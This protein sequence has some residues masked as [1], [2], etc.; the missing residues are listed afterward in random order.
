M[1]LEELKSRRHVLTVPAEK[2]GTLTA[3][4]QR[5]I[6]SL[7]ER[8]KA[9]DARQLASLTRARPF[10]W[11]AAAVWTAGVVVMLVA[12]VESS[13]RNSPTLLLQGMLALVFSGL[14]VALYVQLKRISAID[15]TEAATLFLRKAARRYRFMTP[16]SFVLSLL[17]SGVM[18]LA[19]STYIVDV[20][21]RYLGVEN[22]F[23]GIVSTFVFVGLVYLFGYSVTKKAWKETRE[24]M[25]DEIREILCD[26]E[27]GSGQPRG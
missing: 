17:L 11:I 23:T 2:S 6:D 13:Q 25:L 20:L 10:W 5:S 27:N 12:G 19:A 26:L 24:P 18:A 16:F 1:E 14:A 4:S 8:L 7:I 9:E 3:A 21:K 22:D 15:Y